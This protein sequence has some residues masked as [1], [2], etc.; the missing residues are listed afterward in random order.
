MRRSWFAALLIIVAAGCASA[1]GAQSDPDPL[2]NDAGGGGGTNAD[3][4]A[5][6]ASDA[7]APDTGADTD[8]GVDAGETLP[9]ASFLVLRFETDAPNGLQVDGAWR[10]LSKAGRTVTIAAG[11]PLV[12]SIGDAGAKAMVI[13]N[14]GPAFDLPDVADLRFGATD[15][16]LVVA[17]AT[18]EVP[19]DVT[20]G[21]TNHYIFAKYAGDGVTGAH[22]HV[23]SPNT[24]RG[25]MGSVKL[26][27]GDAPIAIPTDYQPTDFTVL[28]FGRNQNGTRIETYGAGTSNEVTLNAPIDVSAP[29]SPLT[30]GAYRYQG[31]SAPSNGFIGKINRMYV[32]HAPSGTFS[33]ADFDTIRTYVKDALPRP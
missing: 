30:I 18:I 23:C 6:P 11:T 5:I 19:V 22:L 28:S 21:C 17:R 12:A 25:L 15:D 7:V 32:Y 29:G 9:F 1:Y 31:T 13:G 4:S 26:G 24:G 27:A 14:A 20:S 10:D 33:K 8:A 16:F 3:G 2:T